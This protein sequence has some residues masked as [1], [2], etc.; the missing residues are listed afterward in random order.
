MHTHATRAA[1]K[2]NKRNKQIKNYN[3]I[4]EA[5]KRTH[6]R[7]R[8]STRAHITRDQANDAIDNHYPPHHFPTDLIKQHKNLDRS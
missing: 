5:V 8:F 3:D 6:I 2:R 7:A 1:T 4:P